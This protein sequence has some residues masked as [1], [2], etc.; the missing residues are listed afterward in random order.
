MF[1]T[2]P[3]KISEGLFLGNSEDAKNLE[4]LQELGI[5]YILIAGNNLNIHFPKVDD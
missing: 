1:R 3:S 2:R 5:K 4:V